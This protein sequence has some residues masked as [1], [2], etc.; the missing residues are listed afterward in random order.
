MDETEELRGR[1]GKLQLAQEP[2]RAF[3]ERL[4]RAVDDD[5]EIIPGRGA[6]PKGIIYYD[7][8]GAMAAQIAPDRRVR[9]AGPEPTPEEAKAALADYVAYF[10]TYTIDERAG[11]ITHHRQASVQPGELTDYVRTYEFAGDRLILRPVGTRQEVVWER[12][13]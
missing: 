3:A 2:A 7:P 13:K 4:V 5:L 1:V 12:F 11:T 6:E 8:S 9:M 10:G